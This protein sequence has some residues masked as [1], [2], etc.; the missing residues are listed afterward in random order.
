MLQNTG[1]AGAMLRR[2]QVSPLF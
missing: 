1:L 2:N